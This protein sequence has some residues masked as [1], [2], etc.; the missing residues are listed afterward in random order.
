LNFDGLLD[1]SKRPLR[2][3]YQLVDRF[4]AVEVNRR[5]QVS[6]F[7]GDV[8]GWEYQRTQEVQTAMYK[9]AKTLVVDFC[10]RIL[11]FVA[12]EYER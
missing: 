12:I 5:F 6:L 4:N 10:N 9:N 3:P 11:N 2:F 7:K 1:L 8:V